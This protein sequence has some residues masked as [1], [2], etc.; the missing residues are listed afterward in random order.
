MIHIRKYLLIDHIH[1]RNMIINTVRH[2]D[3]ILNTVQHRN[4]ILNT[5][6][7]GNITL[8]T[9]TQL[10]AMQAL[11]KIA[12]KTKKK[13]CDKCT[14]AYSVQNSGKRKTGLRK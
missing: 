1:V 2:K 12:S 3:L 7:Y 6:Q 4:L 10:F 5:V 11:I 9:V 13:S 8:H 14:D